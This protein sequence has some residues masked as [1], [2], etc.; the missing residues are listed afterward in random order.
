MR[1]Y[2]FRAWHP[3]HKE[4]VYFKPDKICK[5]VYQ[6]LAVFTLMAEKSEFLQQFIGLLDKDGKEIYEG[7]IVKFEYYDEMVIDD[8][9]NQE[10]S[11]DAQITKVESK[12]I[13]KGDFEECQMW[14][15]DWAMD[16]DYIFEIIGNIYE[17]P[18]LVD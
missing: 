5:D 9:D 13:I 1:E 6:A 17:N 7:D 11:E 8:N 10:Y 4:M 18:E 16:S 2:K 14:L 12:G 3:E 15:I